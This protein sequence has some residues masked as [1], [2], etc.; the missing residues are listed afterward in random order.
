MRKIPT[1]FLFS[2]S[3]VFTSLRLH[4]SDRC[5]VH[6]NFV[7]HYHLIKKS[8]AVKVLRELMTLNFFNKIQI[9]IMIIFVGFFVYNAFKFQNIIIDGRFLILK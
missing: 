6:N 1:I 3:L 9:Y 7:K 5:T 8:K 2:N 4:C